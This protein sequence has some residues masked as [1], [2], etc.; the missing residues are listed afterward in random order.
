[1]KLSLGAGFNR[2]VRSQCPLP[3]RA[4]SG[5]QPHCIHLRRGVLLHTTCPDYLRCQLWYS[6]LLSCNVHTR[7]CC[8]VLLAGCSL[9][10][11]KP[12]TR[13]AGLC[14][15]TLGDADRINLLTSSEGLGDIKNRE[16]PATIDNA[17]YRSH[18]F[19][20]KIDHLVAHGSFVV[21]L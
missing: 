17:P 14:G 13:L 20:D 11:I 5:Y 2:V 6:T 12:A 10:L 3:L 18:R 9:A 19:L 15:V 7:Q 4:N 16:A 21:P 8:R 1:M